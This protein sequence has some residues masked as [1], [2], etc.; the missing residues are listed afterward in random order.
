MGNGRSVEVDKSGSFAGHGALPMK[1][2]SG[3]QGRVLMRRTQKVA[4]D[5]P[6]F[7]LEKQS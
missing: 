2:I 4:P 6:A 5:L 7:S 1:F 3:L